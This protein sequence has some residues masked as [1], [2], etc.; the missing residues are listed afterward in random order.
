MLAAVGTVPYYGFGLKAFP[1]ALLRPGM[2]QLRV[3]GRVGVGSLLWNL[4]RV[5]AG[6]FAHPGLL[7]F[8]VE[9]VAMQFER[10]MPLQVGGDAEGYRDRLS[11]GMAPRAVEVVDFGNAAAAA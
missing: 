10:P 4:P 6:Q 9:K 11:I 3:L 2:M 7:D 8:Q 5:W 1:F